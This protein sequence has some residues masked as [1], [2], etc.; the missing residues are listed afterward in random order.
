MTQPPT[1]ERRPQPEGEGLSKKV[2]GLPTWGWIGIAAA[3]GVILLLWLQSRKSQAA[4]S[5]QDSSVPSTDQTGAIETLASQIRDLQGAGS[6]PTTPG[7]PR[8]RGTYY[9]GI[10]G[11]PDPARRYLGI[12]GV[13][14]YW[15]P[16]IGTATQFLSSHPQTISLGQID[17][18]VAA[19]R[20]GSLLPWASF[21]TGPTQYSPTNNTSPSS[22][23]DAGG[24]GTMRPL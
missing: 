2:A 24:G 1:L 4:P 15:V 17:Q 16:D 14:Y 22:L 12:P 23:V 3:G 6:Q 5:T 21:G 10:N 8:D 11:D 13:G 19:T 7:I 20:F 18:G 9:F